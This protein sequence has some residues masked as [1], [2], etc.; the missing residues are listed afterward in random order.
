MDDKEDCFAMLRAYA[1]YGDSASAF[2]LR[3]QEAWTFCENRGWIRA[4]R[5]SEANDSVGSERSTRTATTLGNDDAKLL[6]Q[7]LARPVE[8]ESLCLKCLQGWKGSPTSFCPYCRNGSRGVAN[9][10]RAK[11]C[12]RCSLSY[13]S[14]AMQCQCGEGL[15]QAKFT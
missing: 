10:D 7:R 8:G 12:L 2:T 14:S 9:E 13:K 6:R 15:I 5:K 3:A 1:G 11:V 4:G